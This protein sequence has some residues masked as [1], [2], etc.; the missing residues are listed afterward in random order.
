MKRLRRR[1]LVMYSRRPEDSNRDSGLGE[2]AH[3]QRYS[4]SDRLPEVVEDTLYSKLSFENLQTF[5]DSTLDVESFAG[6]AKLEL[7][8]GEDAED[9]DKSVTVAD[10]QSEM[11]SLSSKLQQKQEDDFEAEANDEEIQNRAK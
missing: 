9:G 11:E 3:I 4:S 7:R 10:M 5:S 8:L 6:H 1:T 2:T